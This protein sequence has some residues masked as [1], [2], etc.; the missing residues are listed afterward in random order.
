MKKLFLITILV[1][2]NLAAQDKQTFQYSGILSVDSKLIEKNITLDSKFY[3]QDK[4]GRKSPFLA[5]IISLV[6]PGAGEIYTESYWKAA[7]FVAIETA[8]IV[9]NIAYNKKGDD[10]TEEFKKYADGNWSAVRYAQW[11]NEYGSQLT[12]EA[13]NPIQINPDE[14]L[15]PWER[16]DFKQINAAEDKIHTFS[17]KLLPY[18]EQQYYELIGKYYQ[19]R[20]GWPDY[21]GGSN[22]LNFYSE[23]FHKYGNMFL[24]PDKIYQVASTAIIIIITNHF[25]SAVDAAWSA[26]RYNKNLT[27]NVEIKQKYFTGGI[28]YYPQFNLQYRF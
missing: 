12:E 24:E 25:L 4:Q 7:I 9:V 21:S 11:L 26:S 1:T 5:G 6:I 18:G 20:P 3:I 13:I 16:V 27:A 8:A 15:K 23:E 28:D 17:H 10:K 22:Y 14:S 19:F 2:M